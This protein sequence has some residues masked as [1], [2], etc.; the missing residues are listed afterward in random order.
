MTPAQLTTLAA[1]IRA[2]TDPAVVAALDIRNDVLLQDLYNAASTFIVWRSTIPV[3]EYRNAITWTE[4]DA[5]TTGSKYR[6]WEWMTGNMT[7]PLESG[8]SSVRTGLADCWGVSTTTRA[9]LLTLAKRPATKA[10]KL[11]VT[12]TGTTATPGALGWE[13]RVTYTTVGIALGANP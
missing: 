10:E 7:L 13:G 8:K 1:A 6:I 4:V 9:A 11:F 3:E 12:G 2:D 5:L